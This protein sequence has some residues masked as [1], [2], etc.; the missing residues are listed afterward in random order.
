MMLLSEERGA[1]STLRQGS[2]PGRRMDATP[3][4][5]CQANRRV[6]ECR[7]TRLQAELL[8]GGSVGDGEAEQVKTAEKDIDWQS[9]GPNRVGHQTMHHKAQTCC[10]CHP[11]PLQGCWTPALANA[12]VP[13]CIH[14]AAQDDITPDPANFLGLYIH[15]KSS[16]LSLSST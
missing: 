7:N 4:Q 10:P 12:H 9:N 6:P 13:A 1:T 11:G 15:N 5:L 3:G 16:I 2:S 14:S 8:H